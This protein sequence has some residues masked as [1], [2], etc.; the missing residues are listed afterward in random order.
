MSVHD[1]STGE[2]VSVPNG[3]RHG[4]ETAKAVRDDDGRPVQRRQ[5]GRDVL[6]VRLNRSSNPNSFRDGGLALS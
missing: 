2:A 5:E 1:N 6:G 4:N 3:R